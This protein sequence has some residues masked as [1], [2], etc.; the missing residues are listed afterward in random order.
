MTGDG[1]DVR[2]LYGHAL[3][4][5][6]P[7]TAGERGPSWHGTTFRMDLDRTVMRPMGVGR[8]GRR[9]PNVSRVRWARLLRVNTLLRRRNR[10]HGCPLVPWRHRVILPHVEIDL[11]R[12][13]R[14]E[15]P[16]EWLRRV[17]AEQLITTGGRET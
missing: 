17:Q 3:S 12:S 5:G 14:G 13:G 4:E 1:L 7:G 9:P 15:T 16:I 8:T 2:A 6:L 11:N 10:R